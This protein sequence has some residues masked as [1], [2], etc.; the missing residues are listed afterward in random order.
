MSFNVCVYDDFFRLILSEF[1]FS[2]LLAAFCGDHFKTNGFRN[3]I[4]LIVVQFSV[5][6]NFILRFYKSNFYFK[7]C[8][9]VNHK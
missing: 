7:I 5:F 2:I 3:E 9:G 8:L 6:A 1:F 4:A